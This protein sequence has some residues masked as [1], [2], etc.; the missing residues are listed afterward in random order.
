MWLFRDIC[1]SRR[2]RE[3]VVGVKGINKVKLDA[4][5]NRRSSRS[6]SYLGSDFD[7]VTNQVTKSF[8]MALNLS[9]WQHVNEDYLNQQQK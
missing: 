5:M 2:S 7:K 6:G 4:R 3:T 9:E 1:E 8:N